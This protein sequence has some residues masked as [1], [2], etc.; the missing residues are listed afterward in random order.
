MSYA[1][2]HPDMFVASGAFSGAV[3]TTAD[4]QGRR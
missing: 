4:P 1:S 2:R 3:E